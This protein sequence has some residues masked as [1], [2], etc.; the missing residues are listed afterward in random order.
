MDAIFPPKVIWIKLSHHKKAESPMLISLGKTK[1]FWAKE[2]RPW[3]VVPG[4]PKLMNSVHPANAFAY[5]VLIS[6]GIIT[7][8]NV[9]QF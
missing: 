7:H 3:R 6:F 4:M 5:I 9:V 8:S 2:R 1:S